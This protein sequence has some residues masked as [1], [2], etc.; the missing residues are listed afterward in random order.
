MI[1]AIEMD[2]DSQFFQYYVLGIS[3]LCS[4]IRG[5]TST[6]LLRIDSLPK[7]ALLG[8]IQKLCRTTL[9]PPPLE[10]TIV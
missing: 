7:S 3:S 2:F 5:L 9:T 8:V 6:I 4:R 10:W 1:F